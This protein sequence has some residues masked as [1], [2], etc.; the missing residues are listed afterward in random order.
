[1]LSAADSAGA[2]VQPGLTT[3][4][5]SAG[6]DG[7]SSSAR[8]ASA[9][10]SGARASAATTS[11]AEDKPQKQGVSNECAVTLSRPLKKVAG[12][13]TSTL[14]KGREG[15]GSSHQIAKVQKKEKSDTSETADLASDSLK[16]FSK[17][18]PSSA[19]IPE[20][21]QGAQVD[22]PFAF[23][24]TDDA[25][26]MD[27]LDV[28]NSDCISMYDLAQVFFMT[29]LLNSMNR[30]DF[31]AILQELQDFSR[32]E[33]CVLPRTRKTFAELCGCRPEAL[34][35]VLRK[36]YRAGYKKQV[37]SLFD[38]SSLQY[39]KQRF[40]LSLLGLTNGLPGVW[41]LAGYFFSQEVHEIK[42]VTWAF[43]VFG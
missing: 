12:K 9:A 35:P 38:G 29:D 26:L 30:Q 10:S 5:S 6:G 21:L 1:M 32:G 14:K 16:E 22:A 8:R 42:G 24:P 13:T 7:P 40:S 41:P 2:K 18:Q 19:V 31:N 4:V 15:K 27:L 17:G 34:V 11:A 20:T 28:D 25:D 23:T 33:A 39:F 43:E 36:K 3:L 37:E